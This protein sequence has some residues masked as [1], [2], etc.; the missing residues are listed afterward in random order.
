MIATVLV[1]LF[2]SAACGECAPARAALET[3]AAE[4]G[5]ALT[6]VEHRS[7]P[8]LT[9]A[10]V[11]ERAAYYGAGTE[12]AAFVAGEA[13]AGGGDPESA[14]R[15]AIESAAASSPPLGVDALFFFEAESRLG[16]VVVTA[17]VSAGG[18]VPT[19]EDVVIR[20]VVLEDPVG[21]APRVSRLV[22][23]ATPLA[24]SAGGES[25]AFALAF[26]LGSGWG[27]E[28]L[29]GIV[30]AQ[31]ESDRSVVAAAEARVSGVLQPLPEGGFDF[32]EVTLLPSFPNP[33]TGIVRLSFY[34]PAADQATLRILDA[35]GRVVRVLA[36]G[37]YARGFHPM[38]WDGTDSAGRR[39]PAGVF[40]YALETRTRLI[41]RRLT[42]LR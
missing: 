19:P 41:G 17:S 37:A 40:I 34:L 7:D 38:A 13:V 26:A 32:S 21:L 1:E 33:S 5:D 11:S 3:L 2:G 28:R 9:H 6:W 14:Y 16:E 4:L 25:Q 30:F 27:T 20:V 39:V 18:S 10:G 36:S 29:A 42:L 12:P 8:G 23:P 15:A 31:R 22:L 24:A 35:G